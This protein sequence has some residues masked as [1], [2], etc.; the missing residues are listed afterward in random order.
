LHLLYARFWH[1]VL[2]DLGYVSTP[3]P[4]M[5]L[6]HQGMIL[7]ED[8]NKMSKSRG[9]V[10]NPDDVIEKYGADSLRLFEMFIG[11]L[12]STKPWSTKGIE[13][14]YRFLNR[15]WRLFIS[16]DGS[17]NPAI[18]DVEPDDETD[19]L[20][21]K[22]IKAITDDIED[23]EMKFNTCVSE[24]MIFVNGVYGREKLPKSVL[25]KFLK[26]LSPFAPHLAEELWERLGHSETISFEKWPD[27]DAKKIS[28]NV[29]TVVGQVNGK[30][31]TKI[32]VD[33]DLDEEKLKKL[34][35]SDDKI[36]KYINGKQII[37]EIVVKNKLVNIVIK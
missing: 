31:R 32:E 9:N 3:E 13:G 14:V 8:S 24:L 1:K 6:Y 17:L 25:E 37:K 20:I 11:P 18:Q 10:I 35:K 12:A 29:V 27:Y 4:F 16:E 33:T 26:L 5:K 30:I 23:K 34:I 21:N 28:K 7:G 22:T 36:Q 2:Y 19:R 15:V